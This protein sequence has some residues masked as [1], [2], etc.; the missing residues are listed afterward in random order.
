MRM[1]RRDRSARSSGKRDRGI[2]GLHST[3][4]I[5]KLVDYAG[6]IGLRVIFDHHTNDGGDHGRGGLQNNGLWFEKGPVRT[7]PMAME[8]V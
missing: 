2:K 3:Q 1:P 6:T 8:E 7:E 5:V 4:V